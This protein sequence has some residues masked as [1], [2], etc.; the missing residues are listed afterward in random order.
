MILNGTPPSK[1]PV[2]AN[3]RWNM[4]VNT[5]LLDKAGIRVSTDILQKAVKVE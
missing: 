1:I 2:V 3:R 5:G 4:Y